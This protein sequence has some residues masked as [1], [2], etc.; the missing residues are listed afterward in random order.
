MS[1]FRQFVLPTFIFLVALVPLAVPNRAVHSDEASHWLRRVD[2]F[3]AALAAGAPAGTVQTE[4]P[5]VTVMALGG[6][7][8]WATRQI[9]PEGTLPEWRTVQFVRAPIL[10]ANALAVLLTY[11]VLRRVFAPGVAFGAALLW[12]TEPYWRWYARLVHIDGLTTAYMMLSFA[13]VMLALRV[14]VPPAG[15]AVPA[16]VSW[17]WLVLAGVAG[18]VA[19]LTRFTAVYGVGI[20]GLAVIFNGFAYRQHM[21][22]R[23]FLRAMVLPVLVYVLAFA[24]TWVALYPAAWTSAGRAAIWAETLHGLENASDVHSLGNFFL[25]RPVDDPGAWFYVVAVPFRTAP[26]VIVGVFVGLY[27]ALTNRSSQQWRAWLL[28]ALYAGVY[29]LLLTGQGK[30]LDRYALPAYPALHLIAAGGWV[31]LAGRVAA[32]QVQRALAAAAVL[33]VLVVSLWGYPHDYAYLNPLLGGSDRAQQMMLISGGEG[34]EGA[35]QLLEQHDAD[36]CGKL[37]ATFYTDLMDVQLPCGQ[38]MKITNLGLVQFYDMDYVLRDV[39]YRQRNP[40]VQWLYED[41]TPLYTVVRG[42]VVYV[43]VYRGADLVRRE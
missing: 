42:G 22:L 29:L 3:W 39:G 19:A 33:A 11:L 26:W 1:R 41:V 20:V 6:A 10:F 34:L 32:V 37:V 17:R 12:A 4:H 35:A 5:G 8:A 9:D 16:P 27:A 14:H 31:W 36:L 13:L 24:L 43:Q 30:K 23:L 7:G 21:S 2:V 25:G 15:S 18:G 38:E 40:E 28:V